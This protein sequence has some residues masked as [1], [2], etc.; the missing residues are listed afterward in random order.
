M[1]LYKGSLISLAGV[2][3]FRGTYFGVFDTL[4]NEK[5]S[6]FERFGLAYISSLLAIMFTYPSDTVRRRLMCS[7]NNSFKYNGF[8]DCSYKVYSREGLKSFFRGG[9]IMF[10]Q[11]LSASLVLFSYDKIANDI[12][13]AK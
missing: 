5:Q 9:P 2:A 8:M 12:K 11:S 1:E 3:I 6:N 7:S 4:K 10:F 13:L